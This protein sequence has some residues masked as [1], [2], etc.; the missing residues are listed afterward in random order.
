[1]KNIKFF[2]VRVWIALGQMSAVVIWSLLLYTV[3]RIAMSL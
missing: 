3:I 2:G 1:M